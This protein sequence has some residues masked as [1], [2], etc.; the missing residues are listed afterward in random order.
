MISTGSRFFLAV[1]IFFYSVLV[2]VHASTIPAFDVCMNFGCKDKQSV[3]LSEQDWQS[4]ANWFTELATSA[5][6][7]RDQVRRAIGWMEVIVG[8]YTPTHR[9]VGGNLLKEEDTPFPGQLDCID[10]S[11]NTTTYL[12]LFEQSGLLRF[13]QVIDRA[14]RRTLFDQ[15]WAGQLEVLDSGERWVVDSWFQNNGDLPYL[16]QAV[17]WEDI[18]LITSYFDSSQPQSEGE[19]KK[20]S[21]WQRLIRN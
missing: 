1:A 18:P 8:R 3:T 16:Q 17:K 13:H 9:D 21:F 2:E 6:Q 14:Y 7:E 4:V 19:E 10:E 11:T 15:H 12:K 20:K 5:E